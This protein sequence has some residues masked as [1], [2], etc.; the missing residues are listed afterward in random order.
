MCS[1]WDSYKL[2]HD[3]SRYILIL[4]HFIIMFWVWTHAPLLNPADSFVIWILLVGYFLCFTLR[5]NA[6]L[7]WCHQ[8]VLFPSTNQDLLHI[9]DWSFWFVR[10]LFRKAFNLLHVGRIFLKTW[11]SRGIIK[12]QYPFGGNQTMQM[13]GIFLGDFPLVVHCLGFVVI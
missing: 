5:W 2:C 4:F 7:W 6:F 8:R 13:Y 11:M 10:V 3:F 1:F 12:L 9:K